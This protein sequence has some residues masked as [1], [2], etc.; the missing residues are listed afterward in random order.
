MVERRYNKVQNFKNGRKNVNM[1]AFTNT[2]IVS[3]L[4]ARGPRV[5]F[6]E[7]GLGVANYMG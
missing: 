3:G 2:A 6:L 5:R 7:F 4:D 1:Q